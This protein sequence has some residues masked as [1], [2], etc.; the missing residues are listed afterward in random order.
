MPGS[1]K[2]RTEKIKKLYANNRAWTLPADLMIIGYRGETQ[3][4][5]YSI[6]KFYVKCHI[7]S[8]FI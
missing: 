8:N 7:S 2:Q 3:L 4:R 6:K 1:N 5:F